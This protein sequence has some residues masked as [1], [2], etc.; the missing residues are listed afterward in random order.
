M[1]TLL[2]LQELNEDRDHYE[3]VASWDTENQDHPPDPFLKI[4]PQQV[5]LDNSPQYFLERIDGPY[6]ILTRLDR[7]R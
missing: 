7:E 1:T 4:Y 2:L 3:N 5:W 6:T